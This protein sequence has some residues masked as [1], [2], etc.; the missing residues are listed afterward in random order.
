MKG[1]VKSVFKIQKEITPQEKK[2]C[3]AIY[4]C[5]KREG[6]RV[7]YWTQYYFYKC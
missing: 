1:T 3:N 7:G 5:Q 2:E 4:N 6:A